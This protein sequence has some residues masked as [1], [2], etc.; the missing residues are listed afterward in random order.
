MFSFFSYITL[1]NFC[2]MQKTNVRNLISAN[3][4]P[5]SLWQDPVFHINFVYYFSDISVYNTLGTASWMCSIIFFLWL[6]FFEWTE[7]EFPFPL[8][9]EFKFF[10]L[11]IIVTVI[12]FNPHM[13]KMGPQGPKHNIFGDHFYSKNAR[14][15]RFHVFL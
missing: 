5:C 3:R 12:T 6:I 9:Q 4:H 10:F 2:T 15:L 13:H 7:F 11:G 1:L 8:S 14:K